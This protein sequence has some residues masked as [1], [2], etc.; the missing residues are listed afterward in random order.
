MS[1]IH[2]KNPTKQQTQKKKNI[3]KSPEG[4]FWDPNI[5]DTHET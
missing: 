2:Q 3:W 1:A 5:Q 4:K